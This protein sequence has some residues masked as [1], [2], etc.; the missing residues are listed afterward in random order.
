M[1]EPYLS[2]AIWAVGLSAVLTPIA[3][4]LTRWL[5]GLKEGGSTADK[6]VVRLGGVAVF[7]S[8]AICVLLVKP[9]TMELRGIVIASG[10]VCILGAIE[11]VRRPPVF[12]R[13]LISATAVAILVRYGMVLEWFPATEWWGLSAMWALTFLWMEGLV[14][15]FRFLNGLG[16][17]AAGSAAINS[18][19]ICVY[20]L[21]IRQANLSVGSLALMGASLGFLPYNY[22]PFR[23]SPEA[24]IALGT[25]GSTFIGFALGSLTILGNWVETN[26]VDML[27]PA[28]IVAVPILV[29]VVTICTGLRREGLWRFLAE[30]VGAHAHAQWSR[31]G[32]RKQ[33]AVA[34][35]YLVNLC[36]GLSAFLLKGSST[37]DAFLVLGQVTVIFGIIAY[38]IMIMRKR[39]GS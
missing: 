15:A 39:K 11:D 7:V 10:L 35:I 8:F 37:T 36:F 29:M 26:P 12:L 21:T 24:G 32:I 4:R 16:G 14:R 33:E 9:A 23:R 18:L 1:T 27:V 3:G 2:V 19:F 28:L 5:G 38:A 22:K 34:I 25:G 31:I 30:P 17:L 20:A 6:P 13:L